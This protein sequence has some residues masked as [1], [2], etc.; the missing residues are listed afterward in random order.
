MLKE[1]AFS[2]TTFVTVFLNYA[3]IPTLWCNMGTRV[4]ELAIKDLF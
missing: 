2:Y 4:D 3:V 1:L